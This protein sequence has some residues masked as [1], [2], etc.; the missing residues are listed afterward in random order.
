MKTPSYFDTRNAGKTPINR[1]QGTSTCAGWA[2]H[3]LRVR[4]RPCGDAVGCNR[5][6][7]SPHEPNS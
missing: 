4:S 1:T 2:V 3:F 5:D 6:P 7:A